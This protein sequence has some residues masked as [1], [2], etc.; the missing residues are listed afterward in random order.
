MARYQLHEHGSGM[1]I[2]L[3]EV[4]GEQDELLKAFGE[5]QAGRC[6]CPT[7]EYEKVASMKVDA[8]QEQISIR[9]EAKPETR[10]SGKQVSACLDHTIA[11][12]AASDATRERS[13]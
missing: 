13:G 7:D 2:E 1:T 3:T 11:K 6:S 12:V 10:F 4:G 5:C 8:G 9:L